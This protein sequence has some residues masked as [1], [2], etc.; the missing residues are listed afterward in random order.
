MIQNRLQRTMRVVFDRACGRSMRQSRSRADT[1]TAV[2]VMVALVPIAIGLA[3][4]GSA[5]GRGSADSR[6]SVSPPNMGKKSVEAIARREFARRRY[7][8]GPTLG[9]VSLPGGGAIS[10]LAIRCTTE[11][12]CYELA[13]G[14][15]E[16]ARYGATAH[17][18]ARG[19]VKHISLDSGPAINH[20]GPAERMGLDMTIDH[21]CAGPPGDQPYAFAW[22][23][24]RHPTDIVTD[25]ADGRT[26][27]MRTATIPARMHPEGML[28][29]G[30]LLPGSNEIVV[31]APDGHVVE[32]ESWT[33]SNKEVS[34]DH[35]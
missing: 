17:G 34:C 35:E 28:V 8:S 5:N 33:G 26:I 10:V 30:L 11:T 31:R 24:L 1:C 4:C 16:P 27:T 25:R 12:D 7:A 21:Q 14:W 13:Q 32:R 19:M 15:E 22:G 6:G 2:F 9:R 23:L 3:G 29:Y 20:A 18:K